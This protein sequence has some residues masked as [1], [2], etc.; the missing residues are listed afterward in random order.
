MTKFLC[1]AVS[2]AALA[3]ACN[4]DEILATSAG[5]AFRLDT[6]G[7]AYSVSSQ[8]AVAS[9]CSTTWR[10][11]ET[12]TVTAPNGTVTTFVTDAGSAGAQLFVPNAGGLWHFSNSAS[13]SATLGVPYSVFGDYDRV[14]ATGA[15]ASGIIVDTKDP[16]PNRRVRDWNVLPIAYS[17]DSWLRSD[18][19]A[20]TLAL[21]SPSGEVEEVPLVGTGCYR[22]SPT[23][24]GKWHVVLS[25][26]AGTLES[27]LRL[28][29]Y[30]FCLFFK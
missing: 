23:E 12:V 9:M 11:G 28:L 10:K 18:S 25:S 5:V 8:D 19:A 20:S 26:S 27:E 14:I 3:L 2:A 6:T 4:A 17:G 15:D 29:P 16:G 24:N 13:G 21:T 1:S 7:P 30:G 22:Y